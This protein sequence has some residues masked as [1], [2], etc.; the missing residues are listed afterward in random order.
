MTRRSIPPPRPKKFPPY[1]IWFFFMACGLWLFQVW[2]QSPGL[3]G[4]T[5]EIAVRGLVLLAAAAAA[6][7]S[8]TRNLWPKSPPMVSLY[9]LAWLALSRFQWHLCA[10]APW[11]DWAAVLTFLGLAFWIGF[12]PDGKLLLAGLAVAGTILD[13]VWAQAVLI[14]LIF[15]PA[16]V[17][18]F[19]N[20]R[21]V[22]VGGVIL[23]IVLFLATRGWV[24]FRWD[25][26]DFWDW[27]VGK[28]F[29]VFGVLAWLGWAA[30]P[31]K[32]VSQSALTGVAALSLGYLFLN[33]FDAG[34]T[35]G[36]EGLSWIWIW[37]AGFG[38]E[39]LRRDLLD[40]SWHGRAAWAALGLGAFWGVF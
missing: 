13:L 10:R 17:G 31:R 12:K 37:A 2:R 22:R 9:P 33:P 35:P 34:R 18:R 27:G 21:W 30:F 25:F 36:W 1:P 20:V 6:Y 5:W 14:P 15:L 16:R 32:G 7:F 38:F 28:K 24:H 8:L 40:D 23:F 29:F 11:T 26:L 19:K 39:S 3:Y 4:E